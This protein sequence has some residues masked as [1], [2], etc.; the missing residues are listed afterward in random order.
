MSR[1]VVFVSS[2]GLDVCFEVILP[3]LFLMEL[4]WPGAVE[5]K[6]VSINPAASFPD[7][8]YTHIRLKLCAGTLPCVARNTPDIARSGY[9]DVQ[10]CVKL[11]CLRC[12][13]RD[14]CRTKSQVQSTS[15]RGYSVKKRFLLLSCGLLFLWTPPG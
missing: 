2:F 1:V 11:K 15:S 8:L 13:G 9:R 10:S 5:P 3:C 7:L 12:Y 6:D 4:Q 14:W